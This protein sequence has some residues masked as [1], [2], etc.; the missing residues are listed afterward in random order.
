LI[1]SVVA[2]NRERK[3]L[4][5]SLANRRVWGSDEDSLKLKEMKEKNEMSSAQIA[6]HFEGRAMDACTTRY[7]K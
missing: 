4:F 2:N 7:Y 1:V 3:S 6:T 5:F